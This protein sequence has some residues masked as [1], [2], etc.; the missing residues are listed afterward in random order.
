M[1]GYVQSWLDLVVR[2]T[3]FTAGIMWIGASLYFVWL[4]NNLA[5]PARKSDEEHGVLGEL[6]SVHGGGF[7]HNQKYLTGP[8]NEPLPEHLHWFKWEAY[9]T[10]LSGIALMAIVYWAG[11]STYLIDPSVMKLTPPE[12]IAISFGSLVAGWLVYDSLCKIFEKQPIVLG[13]AIFVFLAFAA[14]GLQHLFSPQAA[15]LHVGAIIGTIMVANVAH[16][17]IPGQKKMLAQIRAGQ[18]PDP[19][20]GVLGK[21]RSVHNTYLTLP[22]LFIMLS[23]HYP[24]AYQS[25]FGW[26][27]LAALGLAG[28]MVRYFF[29]LSH[30]KYGARLVWALPLGALALVA[31]AAFAVAPRSTVS[32]APVHF[33]QIAPIVARRCAVCHAAHPTEPGFTSAPDGVLLDTP[34]RIVQNAPRIEAEAVDSRAMPLGN[35]TGMTQ[36]ERDEVGAWIA[37]GAKP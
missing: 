13:I 36:R 32:P 1:N 33:S 14:W 3:H 12:A 25:R 16:V 35:A 30:S 19:R 2:W 4:D 28:V 21:I 23:G 29:I 7:Y 26:L 31:G 34:A 10:W 6:W 5:R 11:A 20:P 17:I 22:V 8:K 18:Q 27:V 37:Q 15:Y 24:M 9:T